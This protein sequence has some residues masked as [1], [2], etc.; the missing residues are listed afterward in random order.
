MKKYCIYYL[1]YLGLKWH[2]YRECLFNRN[3]EDENLIFEIGLR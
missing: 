1:D 3:L 2:L